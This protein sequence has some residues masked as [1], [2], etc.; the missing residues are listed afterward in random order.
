MWQDTTKKSVPVYAT[1]KKIK[2][3]ILF[4]TSTK[5]RNVFNQKIEGF[6][7]NITKCK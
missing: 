5:N 7:Q 2:K 6:L 4:T 3:S 1:M